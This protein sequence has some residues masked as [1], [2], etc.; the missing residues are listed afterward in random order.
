MDRKKTC[1]EIEELFIK[2]ANKYHSLEKIPVDYG[3]G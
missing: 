1:E 3:A 2:L